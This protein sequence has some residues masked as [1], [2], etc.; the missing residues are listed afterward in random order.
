MSTRLINILLTLLVLSFVGSDSLAQEFNFDVTVNAPSLSKA[1]P[2]TLSALEN[3]IEEFYN[4][5]KW[6]SDEFE[7]EELIEGSIQFNIT[8]D[9]S[10]NTFTADMYISSGRPVYNSTYT[11]PLINHVDRNISFSY[12]P[13]EQL[14]DNRSQF[15]DNLS[16]ILTFYAYIIL[17]FDYDSFSLLGGEDHFRTANN[18]LANVPPSVSSVD[19]NWSSLGGDRNRFWMIE[20]LLNTRVQSLRSAM[21]DYHRKGLDRIEV[22]VNTGKAIMFSA[23]KAAAVLHDEYPNSMIIQMFSNSKRAEILEVFK[24]SVKSEQRRVYDIMSRLDPAQAD[25]LKDLR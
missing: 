22:D 24:N 8:S 9:P 7:N 6:T 4:D 13:G 25:F 3:A 16:A 2:Q 5:R 23:I 12:N 1:D 10:A 17:G 21:Y 14:R 15:T 20:N 19:R 11:S 18:I